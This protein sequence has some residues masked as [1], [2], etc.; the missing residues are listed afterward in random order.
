MSDRIP[1]NGNYR[2]FKFGEAAAD[3]KGRKADAPREDPFRQIYGPRTA[4]VA[5]RLKIEAEAEKKEDPAEKAR[6]I[7]AAAEAEAET[8]REKARREGYEAGAK[9]GKEKLERSVERVNR[10]ALELASLKPRLVSEATD[11][12]TNL[13]CAIAERVLGPLA[14]GHPEYVLSVVTRSLA[15]LS[16]RETVTVRVNPSDIQLLLEAKQD[17]LASLDG[18]RN[19]TFLDDPGVP[20][21]GCI[22]E[23]GSTEIDARLKSQLDEIIRALG[24][25]K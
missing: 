21:G 4:A 22:V 12:V 10:I 2:T 16:D 1:G 18:V 3:S 15:A 24:T 6:E 5:E 8:I 20:K 14:D 11:E 9:E 19:L 23:T 7:I 13:A 25:V 17:M